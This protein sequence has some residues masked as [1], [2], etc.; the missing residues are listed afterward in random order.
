[1]IKLPKGSELIVYMV[2]GAIL[3]AGSDL[4]KSIC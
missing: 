4:S 2:I 1:M 3:L